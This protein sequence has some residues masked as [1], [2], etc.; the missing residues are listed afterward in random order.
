MK[1]TGRITT[2]AKTFTITTTAIDTLR[3]DDKGHAEAVFTV[4]NATARPVR[5]MGRPKALGETKKESLSIPGETERDFGG[6]ATEQFTVNFDAAGAPAGKYPFRLD[7]ASALNPDEDFTEG[8][9]V[10]VEIVGVPTPAVE[11]KKG[12]PKWI[13]PVIAVVVLLIGG[14]IAWLL[15]PKS[16]PVAGPEPTPEP[17]AESTPAPGT[18]KLPVVAKLPSNDAKQKLESE[19]KQ[20][21]PCVIVEPSS[22]SDNAIPKDLAISTDP[23]EGTE[24]E[25]GSNVMLLIS[26]GPEVPPEPG[27]VT[28]LAVKGQPAETAKGILEKSCT[29]VPCV[30]I[31]INRVSDNKVAVGRVI[32]T[33]PWAGIQVNAGSKVRMFVSAGTD[34]VKIPVVRPKPLA[35]AIK[36]L[37]NACKPPPK[38]CLNVQKTNLSDDKV[39]L[40]NAIGTKPP[41]G[42]TVK[43]G[44]TI[45]L[46]VS[47]GPELRLVGKYTSLSEKEALQRISN[48]GFT[49]GAVKRTKLS[50]NPAGTQV[51]TEQAPAPG[52]KAPKRTKINLTIK[53]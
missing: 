39:P 13:I 2:M 23:P 3:V 42:G 28:I 53:G 44:S 11:T 16:E 19:C 41:A 35:A 33:F 4:T 27:K 25:V 10:N 51:V 15:W 20:P 37:E 12:F 29:P 52:S 49:V 36:L 6:G 47:S 40:G 45:V 7:V 21:T 26:T 31:E 43:K 14:V 5:G 17:T 9:T 18:Y 1:V 22:V 38:P 46:L 24:V 50:F 8:P 30:N 32:G 48:D 34:E